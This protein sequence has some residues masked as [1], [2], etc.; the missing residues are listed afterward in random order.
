MENK[1]IKF[2]KPLFSIKSLFLF[3]IIVIA[4]S[5]ILSCFVSA[6][7]DGAEKVEYIEFPPVYITAT[8]LVD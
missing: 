2:D 4:T 3:G 1:M 7:A 8:P 6:N 5:I